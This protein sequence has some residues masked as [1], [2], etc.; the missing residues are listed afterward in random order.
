MMSAGAQRRENAEEWPT[1]PF[2]TGVDLNH[3]CSQQRKR[4]RF[5][6]YEIRR[7][8]HADRELYFI[9]GYRECSVAR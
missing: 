7:D 8:W 5:S 4:V 2:G 6:C 3:L 1:T 9:P